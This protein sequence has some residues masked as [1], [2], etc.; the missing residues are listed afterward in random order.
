MT[1]ATKITLQLVDQLAHR[2]GAMSKVAQ[3]LPRWL[4]SLGFPDCPDAPFE[5]SRTQWWAKVRRFTRK[6]AEQIDSSDELP[7]IRNVERLGSHL[8]L[9]AVERGVLAFVSM[10]NTVNCFER[11]VDY[12]LRTEEVPLG[13]IMALFVNRPETDVHQA[14]HRT[15][16][17][18]TLDLIIPD[19]SYHRSSMPWLMR[20]HLRNALETEVNGIEELIDLLFARAA[21]PE[22]QWEDFAG[23]DP[24]MPFVLELL[25]QAIE[26][27]MAGVNILLYGPTG[28]GKTE[29]A[30]VIARELGVT[31]RAIGEADAEGDELSRQGRLEELKFAGR[32]FRARRD[33]LLL[34]DEMEDVF[35]GEINPFVG[36]RS[37]KVFGNRLLE[38]NPVPIIWTTNSIEHCDP[39]LLRRFNFA[40]EMR[41]PP[42]KTRKAIWRRLRDRHHADLSDHDIDALLVRYRLG[43]AQVA[44]A[45]RLSASLGGGRATVERILQAHGKIGGGSVGSSQMATQWVPA[46]VN[47]DH[48]LALIEQRLLRPEAPIAVS[49]CLDGPSGS[50]KSQWARRLAGL[51]GREVM[52][53]RGSDLLS[54]WVGA[55]EKAIAHAFQQARAEGAVLVFDEAEGLLQ[56][57]LRAR[58]SWEISQ[59]NE[60]LTWM[61][62]HPLPFVCTTNLPE[63]LDPATR[64]RFGFRIRFD[65][66]APSQVP[67][68]WNHFFGGQMPACLMAQDS[69]TVGDFAVVARQASL[70]GET[71]P[72]AVARMLMTEGGR[73]ARNELRLLN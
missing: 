19:S 59:V 52:V 3:E 53:V 31:L 40:L 32:M 39:A 22:A 63:T 36:S 41:V 29:F 49:F 14:L 72:N 5:G 18:R 73:A 45:M 50:G 48:D 43:Q 58:H 12:A 7:V 61:E 33:T 28:T 27:G 10:Y 69:L 47:A 6:F 30:K 54:P 38:T 42:L 56:N 55:T 15:S 51:L 65:Y 8:G 13:Q 60:M 71:E 68:A 44:D 57:R 9:S 20:P 2:Y 46:L 16:L 25:R 35:G 23:L 70:L 66:L 1:H 64:R 21:E 11:A 4:D 24:D 26:Q 62:S 37:S 17:L 67:L 34:L